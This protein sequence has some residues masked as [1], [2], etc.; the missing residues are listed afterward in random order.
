MSTDSSVILLG[1]YEYYGT[2]D[3]LS[4]VAEFRNDNWSKLG[5]LLTARY[6]HSAILNGDEIMVVGGLGK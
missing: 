4:T 6:Y 1:G 2:T 3:T 5:D